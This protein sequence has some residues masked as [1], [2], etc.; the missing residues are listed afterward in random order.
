[1]TPEQEQIIRRASERY[2]QAKATADLMERHVHELHRMAEL[3]EPRDSAD[4][5]ESEQDEQL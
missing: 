1:M 5:V 4:A 3:G 2:L